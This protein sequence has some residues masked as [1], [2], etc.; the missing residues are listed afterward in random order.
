MLALIKNNYKTILLVGISIILL[1]LIPIVTE[2]IFKFGN[3][4]GTFI[5]AFGTNG[6]CF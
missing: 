6:I 4:V 5:R 1:P 2:I 3:I